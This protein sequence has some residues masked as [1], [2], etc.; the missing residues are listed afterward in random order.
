MSRKRRRFLIA[1]GVAGGALAVGA[2]VFYRER[3]RLSPPEEA[4]SWWTEW[5][6]WVKAF[7]GGKRPAR[8][9]GDGKLKPIEDAPGSYVLVKAS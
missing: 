7:A 5:Q 3:D 1:G 6:N 9:P 8:R 2:W 4:S